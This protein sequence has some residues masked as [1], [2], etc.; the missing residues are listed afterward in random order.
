MSHEAREQLDSSIRL[1]LLSAAHT[2][3]PMSNGAN[4]DSEQQPLLDS[5]SPPSLVALG[6]DAGGKDAEHSSTYTSGT[7][8]RVAYLCF[9]T[10]GVS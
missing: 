7:E 3:D 5:E 8:R 2:S 6:N 4:D 1:N 9:L 10:L